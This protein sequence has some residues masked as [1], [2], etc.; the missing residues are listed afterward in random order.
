[1]E[2]EH[3][4]APEG[5][6]DD[7]ERLLQNLGSCFTDGYIWQLIPAFFNQMHPSEYSE[8]GFCNSLKMSSRPGGAGCPIRRHSR[9]RF[10]PL[11]NLLPSLRDDVPTRKW[12]NSRCAQRGGGK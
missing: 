9:G 11:A 4:P 5:R 12:P 2:T 6:A 8:K 7:Q 1:M 10:A 3:K